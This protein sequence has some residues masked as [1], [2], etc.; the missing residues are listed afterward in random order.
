MSKVVFPAPVPPEI[1]IFR[2]AFTQPCKSSSIAG[3]S[4]WFASR[5]SEFS[6]SRPK[7]PDRQA[8]PV[9]RKRRNDR[10]HART[11]RQSGVH[12]GRGFVDAAPDGRNNAID[13]AHQVRIVAK[14]NLGRFEQCRSAPRRRA[15]RCS[16]EYRTPSDRS[17][18]AQA[19][20]V[21][22]PRPELPAPAV[23]APADS[24][25]WIRRRPALPESGPPRGAL[26]PA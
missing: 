13:D 8:G 15:G 9:H 21:R 20:Q 16:P 26:L 10:V 1:R 2:R 19:D 6:G 3:V 4:V 17:A 5:S 18:A 7:P 25:E 14:L 22:K 11:V 24:W 12:H 23:P